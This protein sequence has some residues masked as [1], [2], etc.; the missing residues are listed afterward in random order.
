MQAEKGQDRHHDDDQSDK[1]DDRIHR[2]VSAEIRVSRLTPTFLW[3][4][5]PPERLPHGGRLA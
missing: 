1:I 2:R 4:L 3:R 5:R